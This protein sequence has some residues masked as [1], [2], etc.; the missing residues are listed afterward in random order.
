MRQ[1][2]GCSVALSSTYSKRA[3]K[4]PAPGCPATSVGLRRYRPISPVV[5][6][7]RPLKMLRG[8]NINIVPLLETEITTQQGH[9]FGFKDIHREQ[10]DFISNQ[11]LPGQAADVRRRPF[12][13]KPA[14]AMA[15]ADRLICP[16]GN[17]VQQLLGASGPQPRNSISRKMQF[18]K[19]IQVDL[20]RPVLS[21]K[22]I[23]FSGW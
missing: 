12:Y 21:A 3:S 13:L 14:A 10:G 5:L 19:Q 2:R 8:C 6:R 4:G 16:T 22:I 11:F 1:G 15:R 9:P 17:Q 18:S 23:R 7:E 20:G